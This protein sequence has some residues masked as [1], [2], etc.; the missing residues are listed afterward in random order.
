M[1]N[2]IDISKIKVQFGGKNEPKDERLIKL[3]KEAYTGR[4]LVRVALIKTEG[5]KPYSDFKPGISDEFRNYFENQE[6]QGKP[7]PLHVYPSDKFFIMSDDYRAY[8][9]YKEK[10]YLKIM[11]VILGDSESEYI[12]EKSEPFKLPPPKFEVINKR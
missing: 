5:I 12:I 6:Q 2:N 4:L 8:L 3:L 9:L 7:P 1:N 10:N 11:C